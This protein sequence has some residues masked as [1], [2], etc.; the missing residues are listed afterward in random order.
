MNSAFRKDEDG[1]WIVAP[2]LDRPPDKIPRYGYIIVSNWRKSGPS[3][4]DGA[5]V[6]DRNL[7]LTLS[8]VMPYSKAALSAAL[9][10]RG[11]TP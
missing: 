8:P 11:I 10:N 6:I 5:V 9:L 7:G 4:D 1:K 2:L 3:S